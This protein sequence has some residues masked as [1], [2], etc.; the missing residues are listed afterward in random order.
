M[1]RSIEGNFEYKAKEI[2]ERACDGIVFKEEDL[3]DVDE[4]TSAIWN[5]KRLLQEIGREFFDALYNWNGND[6]FDEIRKELLENLD[7]DE[8]EDE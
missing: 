1:I 3:E 4:F 5:N 7:E 6:T 8:D 2:L